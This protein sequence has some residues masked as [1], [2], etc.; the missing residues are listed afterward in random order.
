MKV[1]ISKVFSL[2]QVMIGTATARKSDKMIFAKNLPMAVKSFVMRNFPKKDI[3]FAEMRF[4]SRGMVYVAIL[5]D[6]VQ[7]VFN[8]NGSLA[9][10]A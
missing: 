1:I 10:V 2:I 5:N 4:T 6:G 8:E 3:A 9:H 7:V